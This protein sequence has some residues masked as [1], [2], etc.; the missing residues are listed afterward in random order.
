MAQPD[1][2]LKVPA[3]LLLQDLEC[4]VCFD[5][6]KDTMTTK[7]GHSFCKECISDCLNRK[8]E[9]PSCKVEITIQD[10]IKNFIVD[11]ILSKI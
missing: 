8:H 6:F 7:C 1:V 5:Q 9:C 11:H 3:D 4:P 2:N 10:C